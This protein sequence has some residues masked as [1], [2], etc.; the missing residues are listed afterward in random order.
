MVEMFLILL[1]VVVVAS[2]MTIAVYVL[3]SVAVAASTL[4]GT[5]RRDRSADE[6]DQVLDEI[7]GRR[8]PERMAESGRSRSARRR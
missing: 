2:L 6:L 3:V 7:L 1:G 8:P 4:L 5:V